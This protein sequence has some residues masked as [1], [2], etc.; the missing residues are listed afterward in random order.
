MSPVFSWDR[1][2]DGAIDIIT[3]RATPIAAPAEA[4]ERTP[5]PPAVLYSSL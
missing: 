2:Y 1:H 3:W 4:P 5:S